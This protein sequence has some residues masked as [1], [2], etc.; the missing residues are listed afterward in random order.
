M[1][2]LDVATETTDNPQE[3]PYKF[4]FRFV[5]QKIE[6]SGDDFYFPVDYDRLQELLDKHQKAAFELAILCNAVDLDTGKLK[7]DFEQ[8]NMQDYL[9]WQILEVLDLVSTFGLSGSV[10]PFFFNSLTPLLKHENIKPLTGADW[11]W[12]NVSCYDGGAEELYQNRRF[13]SIF[14]RGRDGEAYWAEGKAFSKNGGESYY[15]NV[16]SQVPITFPCVTRKLETEYI[17]LKENSND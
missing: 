17:D 11:E 16:D 6:D 10:A 14:K 4:D 1:E 12:I 3:D 7:E 9:E 5:K 8:D 15:T 13:S 2:D